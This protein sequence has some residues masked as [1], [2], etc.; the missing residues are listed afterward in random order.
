MLT[1]R[2]VDLL[3]LERDE[4][5]KSPTT[6]YYNSE[7]LKKLNNTLLA[8]HFEKLINHPLIFRVENEFQV[9]EI[10]GYLER[11]D[12]DL[13][14]PCL[15]YCTIGVSSFTY[16]LFLKQLFHLSGD[17]LQL[18]GIYPKSSFQFFDFP[19]KDLATETSA[20]TINAIDSE[21]IGATWQ[22][23]AEIENSDPYSNL[24]IFL[25]GNVI[26]E[27]SNPIIQ[28]RNLNLQFQ[29]TFGTKPICYKYLLQQTWQ[30]K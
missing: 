13:D 23:D 19:S 29:H 3:D 8:D 22:G 4:D 17:N 1:L 27:S 2:R 14:N 6:V 9:E 28:K 15:S 21:T 24:E 11:L 10:S 5:D 26:W 16:E 20:Y 30:S 25:T 12:D 7:C 18:N